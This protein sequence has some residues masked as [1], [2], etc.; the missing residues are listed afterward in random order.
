LKHPY[1]DAV[2]VHS[3]RVP[4]HG[5]E[6]QLLFVNRCENIERTNSMSLHGCRNATD[7]DEVDVAERA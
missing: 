6:D 7:K 2:E 3:V 1:L 5:L 4:K